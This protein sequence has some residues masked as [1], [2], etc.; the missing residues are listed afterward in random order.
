[1]EQEEEKSPKLSQDEETIK[2]ISKEIFPTLYSRNETQVLAEL[3][4]PSYEK[5]DLTLI[6]DDEHNE[7]TILTTL[8]Y[9]NLTKCSINFITRIKSLLKDDN[10]FIE[11]L[12]KK[13]SKG[14]NALLYSAFRGNLE[15]FDKL[16]ENGADI[17]STNSFGLNSLH[18]A[19]QGNFPNIIV[20]LIEKY[21]FNINLKDKNGNSA[22]HWAVSMVNRE[23]IDYLIYYGI[24]TKL[25]DNDNETA[26]GV[27]KNLGNN[28]II[29]RLSV[30]YKDKDTKEKSNKNNSDNKTK[31]KNFIFKNIKQILFSFYI[32][33]EL[34]NQIIILLG[35]TNLYTSFIFIVFF[36]LFV[37]LYF[38]ISKSDAGKAQ[39]QLLNLLSLAEQG[40]DLKSICP[41][42]VINT[43]SKIAHCYFCN[44][45]INNQEFHDQIIDN[46]V[47][48]NNFH[49]Y[50]NYLMYIFINSCFKLVTSLW[51]IIWLDKKN[52][53]FIIKLALI[54]IVISVLFLLA[55]YSRVHSSIKNYN[56]NSINFGDLYS[57]GER[58]V[59][60]NN[61]WNNKQE[62]KNIKKRVR[63]ESDG[64]NLN[65]SSHSGDNIL[66]DEITAN[67]NILEK[68]N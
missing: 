56:K 60:I 49:L 50:I 19:A 57:Q 16:M 44:K 9:L 65:L 39:S 37:F 25:K 51:A 21:H 10:L 4:N 43:S 45:C 6:I 13:N 3:Y 32:G 47:G 22:L 11:Y 41:W 54:E 23:A 63:G 31:I 30:I 26:Y 36:G 2:K 42:C 38:A 52:N 53:S 33:S 58:S 64:G 68:L 35:F 46:C 20:Y 15:I 5:V 27:A 66:N 48:K 28:D 17:N 18:L 62:S 7:N 59:Q 12:N 8:V 61:D 24:D 55:V 34:L 40:E 1:M 67:Q 29:Q 14:Y